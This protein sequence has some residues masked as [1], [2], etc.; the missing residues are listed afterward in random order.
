MRIDYEILGIDENSD[1][2]T[3]KRAYFKLI[4]KNS[5]EKDPERF[6]EIR[7][8]YERLIEEKDKPEDAI[9]LEFPADDKFALSMFDQI[10]R[11]M[12]EGDFAR[13][14]QT[15]QEGMKHYK[16]IECFL[17]MYARCSILD[18]KT[19]KGVKAYE[20]LVNRYPKKLLYRSELAKAYHMRG[21]GR[22]A[23]AMFRS[24]YETGW[25]ETDFLNLYSMCCFER[26]CYEE[27]VRILQDLIRSIP[28]EKEEQKLPEILE[29]YTGLFML[30]ISSPF[31]IDDTV[32]R[33][34]AFLDRAGSQI[35]DYEEQL[36]AVFLFAHTVASMD[37][38]EAIDILVEKMEELLPVAPGEDEPAE[39][40]EA[41]AL[42]EDERF[43]DLMKI[44]VEAFTLLDD[45]GYPEESFDEYADFMQLDAFL[46][47][48]EAWP[49]QQGELVLLKKEYPNIYECGTEVWKMLKESKGNKAYMKDIVLAEYG[50]KER[51]FQCG[52]YYEFYPEKRQELEQ[53]QWDSQEDGTFVRQGRKIGRNEPC[54]C[55]SGKK[56]KNC[57]GKGK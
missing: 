4:K 42:M 3:I 37:E 9:D 39:I 57:C 22:K 21:Y 32:A 10:Q 33:F 56:Y 53:V 48:L 45:I 36:M 44:T 30:Y 35:H 7:A 28:V 23:Y 11:L 31:P 38:G 41:Y 20:K 50:K 18:G 15:A 27:A 51:K 16:D 17:Y 52:H 54:P 5:P 49:K 29:A 14:A 2:K 6:Q 26:G 34:S 55:G 47:Q 24:T 8:A 43:S 40:A 19:G 1:E 13:A 12:Q 25:R 46:C